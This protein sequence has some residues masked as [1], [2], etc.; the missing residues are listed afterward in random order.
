MAGFPLIFWALI[1]PSIVF[2]IC[3]DIAMRIR[4]NDR[5]PEEEQFSWFVRNS[6]PVVQKYGELYPD[7]YLPLIV[8]CNF[9]LVTILGA[10]FVVNHLWK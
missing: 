8:K 1:I 4:V 7:S 10:A 9:L 6:W 5:L 3:A 2:A